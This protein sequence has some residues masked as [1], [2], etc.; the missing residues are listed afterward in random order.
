[1]VAL[2]LP[3]PHHGRWREVADDNGE[4]GRE[5]GD[6]NGRG[7]DDAP[8]V[9][10]GILARDVKERR[11]GRSLVPTTKARRGRVERR[12]GE[13]DG[14]CHASGHRARGGTSERA[15]HA[16]VWTLTLYIDE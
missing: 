4:G 14:D 1:V 7:D 8:E 11:K 3:D 9:A 16:R 6:D 15:R 12:K 5:T 10:T 2:F 13:E